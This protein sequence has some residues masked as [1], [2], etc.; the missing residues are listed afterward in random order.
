MIF[1]DAKP[2]FP[3]SMYHRYNA[4]RHSYGGDV[5]HQKHKKLS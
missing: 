4:V 1:L 2:K 5:D 3:Y